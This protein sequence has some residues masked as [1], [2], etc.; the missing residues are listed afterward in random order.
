MIF[1]NY[2]LI[3]QLII[4]SLRISSTFRIQICSRSG[5]TG[6]DEKGI[7]L[8]FRKDVCGFSYDMC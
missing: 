8:C 4:S 5:P 6:V 2:L 1:V 3:I 7:T